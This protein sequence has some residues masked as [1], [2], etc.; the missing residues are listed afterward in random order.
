MKF[1]II[2]LLVI[3]S[4]LSSTE[5]LV[6][7]CTHSGGTGY[8]YCD[9]KNLHVTFSKDC[10]DITG[11]RGFHLSGKTNSDVNH[12]YYQAKTVYYLPRGVT[13][14]FQNIERVHISNGNLKEI[15][16]ENLKEFG[17]KLKKLEIIAGN[18]V[19]VIESDLFIYNKN[20]ELVK[21]QNNKIKHIANGA[22]DHL[23]KLKE[24]HLSGN[25]CTSSSDDASDRTKIA[26]VVTNVEKNCKDQSYILLEEKNSRIKILEAQI[27]QLQKEF[28]GS[29]QN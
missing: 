10:R 5:S 6:I 26:A 3:T 9:V 14:Y 13:K 17:D 23:E 11:V 16:K 27:E 2:S 20:V 19:E 24:L 8:Y 1:L 25:S 7:E 28:Q 22:F 12:I 4:Y 29:K 15:T 18:Q 21:I